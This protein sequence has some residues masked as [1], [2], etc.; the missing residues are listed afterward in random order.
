M[1]EKPKYSTYGLFKLVLQPERRFYW[2]ML[3]YGIAVSALSLSV[4]LSVQVLISTV[5]N[6]ALVRQVVVLALVLLTLLLLSGLFAVTQVYL[7]ELFERRFFSRIV[8]EVTLRLAYAR[9]GHMESI[10]RDELVNRYFDIMSVQKSLPA[11]LTGALATLLQTIV[12]VALTSFYHPVFLIFNIVVLFIAYLVY[13]VLDRGASRTAVDLSD[14]KYRAARWLESL[15]RANNFFKSRR[16]IN[17]AIESTTDVREAYIVEHKRHFRYTFTQVVGFYLLYAITSAAL[18]G[19]AG[20]LVIVGQLTVGQ[21]VAA[22]LI[23]TAIF[24]GISRVGY[25]LEL[26]YDLYA[27]MVKLSQLYTMPT[28]DVTER[29]DIVSWEPTIRCDDLSVMLDGGEFRLNME[30]P[31]GSRTLVTTR[32]SAQIKSFTD[33]LLNFDRPASGRLLL[34]DHDVGDFNAHRLRDEVHVI[35]STFFPECTIAEFM[36]IAAPGMTRAA[37][38]ELLSAVGLGPALKSLPDGVDQEL[39]PYGHPLSVAG[40]IKLKIGYALA[41]RPKVLVLTPLFDTLSQEARLQIMNTLS[42]R[43]ETTVLCFTHRGDLRG[44]DRYM[45]WDFNEQRNFDSAEAMLAAYD[46]LLAPHDDTVATKQQL[47]AGGES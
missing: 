46:A 7:M 12:G 11:L 10:N 33:L 41:C 40:V 39:T 47:A 45:L 20:W 43:S 26:Y 32:A 5:V 29:D 28:E 42:A 24:F 8:S 34:D 9:Y 44:C 2:L 16:A 15:S 30:I 21:L 4:P 25:Y 1:T 13:R 38:R 23:L 22:E 36:E 14:A 35:D 3:V 17:Y 37:M 18:L 19:V 27:A 31:A 6:A